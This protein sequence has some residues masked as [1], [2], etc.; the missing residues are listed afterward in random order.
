MSDR[1]TDPATCWFSKEQALK[2]LVDLGFAF[3]AIADMLPKGSYEREM[4]MN[5][6]RGVDRR[7]DYLHDSLVKLLNRIDTK[8][9]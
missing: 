8:E 1:Y 2:E 4:A 3:S 5:A 7:I 9:K 6:S